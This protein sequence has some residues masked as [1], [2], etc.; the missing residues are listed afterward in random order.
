MNNNKYKE[1]NNILKDLYVSG[2]KENIIY[3]MD[4]VYHY[5]IKRNIPKANE[6]KL[7]SYYRYFGEFGDERDDMFVRWMKY[8]ESVENINVFCSPHWRYFCQFVNCKVDTSDCIKMYIPVDYD[9]IEKAAEKIF[10]FLAKNKIDHVSKIG[11]EIRFDD[12]V[13]RLNSKEDAKKL[14]KFI[15][16]DKYIQE[17]MFKGNAFVFSSNGV[18]YAYD[19]NTSYNMCLAQFISIYMNNV[20]NNKSCTIDDV[21]CESFYRYIDRLSKDL[22]CD[23]YLSGLGHHTSKE[24]AYLILNLIKLSLTSDKIDDF[25]KFVD[26]VKNNESRKKLRNAIRNN[27]DVFD[28]NELFKSD[29]FVDKEELFDDVILTTMKKYPM[30]YDK[31]NKNI[32][33]YNYINSFLKGNYRGITRDKGLRDK[34]KNNLSQEDCFEIVSDNIP[35]NNINKKMYNYIRVIMLNNIIDSIVSKYSYKGFLMIKK[36]IRTGNIVS[37]TKN[38]GARTLATSLKASDI[39]DLFRELNVSDLDEYLESYYNLSDSRHRKNV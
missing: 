16:N 36:Y 9:H 39:R 19:G 5:L 15:N 13:I 37:I 7:L 2:K 29:D 22:N 11:S 28:I 8:F 14:Q 24:D 23:R 30:G 38:G 21:N 26:M 1:I 12:I 3:N 32:S 34:V 25:Y 18:N 6:D 20:L 35:G 4:M 10:D 31:D 27:V 17:G 33:G